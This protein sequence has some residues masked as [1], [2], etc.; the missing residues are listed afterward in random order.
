[1][2]PQNLWLNYF[3]QVTV[4]S[5]QRSLLLQERNAL[6]SFRVL[7]IAD[8][9]CGGTRDAMMRMSDSAFE[10]VSKSQHS[11]AKPVCLQYHICTTLLIITQDSE[12]TKSEQIEI[13][14]FI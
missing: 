10:K 7:H 1:M 11:L 14:S 9:E 2:I 8:S 3:S 4:A 6:S 5:L 13:C 12:L